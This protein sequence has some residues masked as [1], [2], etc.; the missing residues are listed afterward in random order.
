LGL[1]T[2]VQ[3]LPSQ[4]SV[5][6]WKEPYWEYPTA[7]QFL[8]LEHE[9]PDKT[10]GVIPCVVRL[11]FGLGV[12]D[13]VVPFHPSMSVRNAPPDPEEP[14]AKHLVVVGHDT[15]DI[16]PFGVAT[17]DQPVPV[18]RS[19]SAGP[20]PKHFV[21][22]AHDTLKSVA[23]DGVGLGAGSAVAD[24]LVPSQCSLSAVTSP[25]LPTAKQFVGLE[26][27]TPRN[28]LSGEMTGVGL[29]AQLVP[30]HC[31]MRG[32]Q[33]VLEVGLRTPPTAKQLVVLEHATSDREAE[34]FGLATIDQ[35]LPFHASINVL[36]VPFTGE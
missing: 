15:L 23:F 16:V 5:S 31:S 3:V 17:R 1:G 29:T 4:C 20:T 36:V 33:G 35:L 7:K 19:M 28:R 11:T 24:Q 21:A 25:T 32:D 22:V 27:P 12:I 30:S 2:T 14:T 6:V 34:M 8:A 26:H 18:G 13:H 10:L 9:T